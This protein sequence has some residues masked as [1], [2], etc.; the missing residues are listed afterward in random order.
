MAIAETIKIEKDGKIKLPD[1]LMDEYD[2]KPFEEIRIFAE[3]RGLRI[4]KASNENPY[5]QFLKF[6]EYGLKGVSLMEIE[7]EREDRCI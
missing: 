1:T 5:D 7:E 6:L 2:L 4:E 3:K